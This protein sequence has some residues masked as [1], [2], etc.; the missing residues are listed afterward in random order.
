MYFYFNFNFI[1]HQTTINSPK[2]CAYV[3]TKKERTNGRAKAN[4]FPLKTGRNTI[5]S[6]NQI[7]I[8]FWMKRETS[9]INYTKDGLKYALLHWPMQQGAS[10]LV[11]E[12]VE[13]DAFE[14][15]VAVEGVTPLRN[16]PKKIFCLA[17]VLKHSPPLKNQKPK[18][19]NLYPTPSQNRTEPKPVTKLIPQWKN[20][21]LNKPI[22]LCFTP[23][24]YKLFVS[25]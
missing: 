25:L 4:D 9:T 16:A 13:K 22:V 3:S 18:N 19:P 21:N 8:G 6:V 23:Y 1:Q 24:I 20:R 14:R 5:Y 12:C 7:G 15:S 11:P 17:K 2:C 10:F